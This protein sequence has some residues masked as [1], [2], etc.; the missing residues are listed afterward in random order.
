[1]EQILMRDM[2]DI[3]AKARAEAM[4]ADRDYY[5]SRQI[6]ELLRGLADEVEFL[7]AESSYD[8]ALVDDLERELRRLWEVEP[9][10]VNNKYSEPE[11]AWRDRDDKWMPLSIRWAFERCADRRSDSKPYDW[12]SQEEDDEI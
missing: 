4:K 10:I 12:T 3:V 9:H 8:D 5:G 2:L 6:V 7:R 1:V 11:I